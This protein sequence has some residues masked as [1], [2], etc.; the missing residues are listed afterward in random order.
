MESEKT[1]SREFGPL[2]MIKDHYPK[3]VVSMDEQFSDSREEYNFI[4]RVN[5]MKNYFIP[6]S[7]D[8]FDLKRLRKKLGMTQKEFAALVNVSKK[9]IERWESSDKEITGPITRLFQ[10]MNNNLELASEFEVPNKTYP[11]RLNYF[12][13]NSYARLLI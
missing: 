10:L 2:L 3:Y 1:I 4:E 5:R 12:F 7:I 8:K 6:K 9:T 13:E 11:L